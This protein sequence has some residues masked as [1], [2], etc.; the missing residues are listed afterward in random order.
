MISEQEINVKLKKELTL[1]K[2]ELTSF[3]SQKFKKNAVKRN[4]MFQQI[5]QKRRKTD[6]KYSNDASSEDSNNPFSL[7]KQ[8]MQE[9]LNKLEKKQGSKETKF[10]NSR[11][12]TTLF[13]TKEIRIND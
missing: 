8:E 3:K 13:E 9:R 1:I 4:L 12:K 5:I 10:M 11:L 6:A 2:Y 7:N